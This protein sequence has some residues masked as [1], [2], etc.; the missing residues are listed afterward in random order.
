MR[1]RDSGR[2]WSPLAIVGAALC[3]AATLFAPARAQVQPP[4]A[5][6]QEPTTSIDWQRDFVPLTE[7]KPQVTVPPVPADRTARPKLLPYTAEESEVPL[8]EKARSLYQQER[9]VEALAVAERGLALAKKNYPP[10]DS[11]IAWW[12][13]RLAA[14]LR[15]LGRLTEAEQQ[16]LQ[17]IEIYEKAQPDSFDMAEA[18]Y[19]LGEIYVYKET[20]AAAERAFKRAISVAEKSLGPKNYFNAVLLR[21]LAQV[22]V[23]QA[24]YR[25]AEA[26]YRQALAMSEEVYGPAN[27][28]TAAAASGLALVLMEL[29]EFSEAEQHLRRALAIVEKELGSNHFATANG[30]ANLALTLDHLRRRAEAEPLYLRSIAI[31]ERLRPAHTGF[32]SAL[33]GFAELYRKQYRFTEADIL[34]KRALIVAEQLSGPRSPQKTAITNDMA[35]LLLDRGRLPEAEALVRRVLALS[36][37]FQGQRAMAAAAHANLGGILIAQARYAE[38][39][40]AVKR[41]LDLFDGLFGSEHPRTVGTLVRLAEL[42]R[43][44]ARY[45]EAEPLLKRA[46]AISNRRVA[47]DRALYVGNLAALYADQ[48]R[49]REALPLFQEA[50]SLEEATW[51]TGSR[52]TVRALNNLAT[53]HAE[54]QEWAKAIATLNRALEIQDRVAPDAPLTQTILFNLG[55]VHAD[56]SSPRAA[57]PFFRR[58]I[59][60]AQRAGNGEHPGTAW[61]HHE[62]ATVLSRLNRIDEAYS[63]AKVAASIISERRTEA[64]RTFAAGASLGMNS[65]DEIFLQ[66]VR[67][68]RQLSTAKRHLDQELHG[69]SFRF[70]QHVEVDA[71]MRAIARMAARYAAGSDT[72]VRL[73]REQQALLQRLPIL[74]QLLANALGSDDAAARAQASGIRS[75]Q[76]AVR[77][78]LEEIDRILR[79]DHPSYANLI[80][81]EALNLAETQALLGAGEALVMIT[82]GAVDCHLFAASQDKSAWSRAT[83]PATTLTAHVATLRRQLDPDQWHASFA[84]FDRTLAHRLYRELWSPLESVL[85]GKT[86]VFVV[87]TGPLTSFPFSV[88]VT[89]PPTSGSAGDAD[90]AALR[91]TAWLAKRHA[92]TT[93]PSAASLKALRL[94]ANKGIGSEPFAG[95]GDPALAGEPGTSR[96]RSIA[97]VFRGAAPDLSELRTLSPLPATAPELKALAKALGATDA[98]VYLRERATEAQLKSLDLSRKRVVAFATH[99]LTAGEL[100]LGE[101][102]LIFTPPRAASERDDGY[103]AASEAA[104]LNLRADWVILS[105]CNTAAGNAPGAKGLSGLARAFFLAGARSLLVSHWPVWDDTAG[106]ITT[107]TVKGFQANPAQGR[108]EAL[109]QAAL[110]LMSD[111]SD[112]RFAHPAAWAPFVLV[113]EPRP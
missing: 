11:R 43:Q 41:A 95:F 74:D 109:R 31:H 60:D 97:S 68:G 62:L 44:Q 28:Q 113:G 38:A 24:K 3:L 78:R 30:L 2:S 63:E 87:P 106:R 32:A 12:H 56:A 49:W 61:A 50:L 104:N 55:V 37:T 1:W 101:P 67:L 15:Q 107:A 52:S 42:F 45:A 51:G 98:D 25:E 10:G 29:A 14:I 76:D 88:L 100:G 83:L 90:P 92:V 80:A 66:A 103:L 86:H 57:E 85:R 16:A 19:Q 96:A 72:L 22:C 108:A 102:G 54:L 46:A 79:R 89:E 36:E 17:A 91:A 58:A 26:H 20:P 94:H 105:A 82:C 48:S 110:A 7:S 64:E 47:H 73:L 23:D 13:G 99:A 5:P 21:R 8:R 77:T 81:G 33:Q 84:P 39:E 18:L 34:Y 59:G 111:T 75:E 53:A 35:L 4:P 6:Q 70:A 112:P 40:V 9:Y 27:V 69:E 93:L 65:D 71:T